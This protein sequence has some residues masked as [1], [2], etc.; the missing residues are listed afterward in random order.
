MRVSMSPQRLLHTAL[1]C[2][3]SWSGQALA[4]PPEPQPGVD[5]KVRPHPQNA[6]ALKPSPAPETH[7][8]PPPLPDCPG[9]IDNGVVRLGVA[10]AGHL[11]IPCP[12]QPVSSG[13]HGTSWVGLRY[14]PTNGEAAAPGSPC[15]GWGVASADLGISG[16]SSAGCGSSSNLTVEINAPSPIS[17]LSVVRVGD[18]FRVTHIYT[19]S[20]VTTFLYQVNVLIENIG[21]AFVADLRYTRGIDYD[22]LPNTFSEYVTVAGTS[23]NPW[24]VGAVDNNFVSLSPLAPDFPVMGGLGDF[25]NLGPGDLGAQFDFRLGSLAPGEV[26]GFRTFYGAAGSHADALNALAA[27]GVSAYSLA[28]GNWNGSGDPLSATGAPTGTYA[29]VTGQPNTFMYGFRPPESPTSCTVECPNLLSQGV[30]T[31][32][33]AGVEDRCVVNGQYDNRVV[34]VTTLHGERVEFSCMDYGGAIGNPCVSAPGADT[35]DVTAFQKLC[36]SPTFAQYCL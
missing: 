8:I 5:A 24:V 36:A 26:R 27:V 19:P 29:A 18:T 11:N 4:A 28:K 2:A 14:L 30:Y 25:T 23:G 3:L 12:T 20:P 22:V 13:T 16:H 1:L 32:D 10:P 31:V 33:R 35:C 15:E 21:T 6:K 7:L 17:T 9:M 34:A